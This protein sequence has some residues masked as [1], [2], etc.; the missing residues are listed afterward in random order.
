[1]NVSAIIERGYGAKTREA[2]VHVHVILCQNKGG[3]AESNGGIDQ[4]GG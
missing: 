3:D 4:Q 2:G 1:V